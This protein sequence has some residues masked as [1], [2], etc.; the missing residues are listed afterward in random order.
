MIKFHFGINFTLLDGLN[1]AIF[2]AESLIYYLLLCIVS[3][4]NATSSGHTYVDPHSPGLYD[5]GF[6]APLR[7]SWTSYNTGRRFQNGGRSRVRNHVV[8]LLSVF[9]ISLRSIIIYF[10]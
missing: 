5:C 8:S 2:N 4:S 9:I 1:C 10:R 3:S 7:T 6:E